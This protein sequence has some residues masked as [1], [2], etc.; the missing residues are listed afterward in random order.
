[1]GP[2]FGCAPHLLD[3]SGL[4]VLHPSRDPIRTCRRSTTR[5]TRTTSAS[6]GRPHETNRV[7]TVH[8]KPPQ[9]PLLKRHGVS[10]PLHVVVCSRGVATPPRGL[11]SCRRTTP[12]RQERRRPSSLS[13]SLKVCRIFL[14]L[15]LSPVSPG[16]V[17]F[18][19]RTPP[20]VP[21]TRRIGKLAQ[22]AGELHLR[23]GPSE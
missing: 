9:Q 17:D 10:D 6:S 7:K 23:R 22:L 14:R 4:T 21:A 12:K 20:I 8:T 16:V 18:S 15:V 2:S 19:R 5:R 3:L 11:P 13:H 1:M